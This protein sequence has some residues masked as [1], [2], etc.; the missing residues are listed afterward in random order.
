MG[1]VSAP[2]SD[3]WVRR[4]S[5]PGMHAV[6]GVPGLYLR[7]SP[8][9][10]RSWILRASVAGKRRDMGVGAYPET[11]LAQAR[12]RARELRDQI[13][14]GSDPVAERQAAR[15]ELQQERD[16][17]VT[18]A[19]AA[20][21]W[22]ASMAPQWKGNRRRS[23]ALARL[24]R[25]AFPT[26][27][28]VRVGDVTRGQVLA[29]L[30]PLWIPKTETATKL[31][32]SMEAVFDWAIAAGYREAE[33][34]ATWKGG[35]KAML[36]AP[37]KVARVRHHP[38]LPWQDVPAFLADLRKRQGMAPRALEFAILT[39][40]RSGEVRGAVWG[41]VDLRRR[42]WTVPAA[43]MK[44]GKA[45]VVHLSD[46]ALALL[47]A[48]PRAAETEVVFWG[49]RGRPLSDMALSMICRRM[50]VAAVPHGF[51]S[52]F[53]DWARHCSAAPDEVSEL[54]LA[55]VSSDATR[56]AYARDGL[57]PQ[58][59]RML[60]DWGRFCSGPAQIGGEVVGIRGGRK[61]PGVVNSPG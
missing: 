52:S 51:R 12:A 58:R 7:I 56:A 10:A 38:A 57:L 15:R 39:A 55:H 26:I 1:R 40:A 60:D 27:G 3:A 61:K 50:G 44:G 18:F 33:N 25:H 28:A 48:L 20:Q 32:Y 43:Q 31:R 22:F 42:I 13:W 37:S 46:A 23:N 59:A 53:K 19:T 45:H 11:G 5:K 47:E 14:R 30:E 49:Q 4:L 21:R 35:L 16:A 54:C 8:A 6:G 17:G 34:P 2:K 41:D 9:G 29:V 36:P 24:E